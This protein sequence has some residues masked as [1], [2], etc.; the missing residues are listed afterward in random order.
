MKKIILLL[1]LL[2]L[3]GCQNKADDTLTVAVSIVPQETFV[4]KVAG[5]LIDVVV[6][7]PPGNSPA[8]YQP[9]PQMMAKFN[10]SDIYFH[11]DVSAEGPILA[12]IGN[13]MKLVDLAEAVDEKYPARYFEA[14]E[15]DHEDEHSHEGRDPH[16]WLSPKRTMVMVEVIR[17][18][19]ITLDPAHK[20]IYESNAQSYL[21][22]LKVLDSELKEAFDQLDS[23]A[24][25]M[26][27]PSFG[28]F[29]EDYNLDMYAIEVEGK[30]AT[31]KELGHIIE[32]AKDKNIKYVFYQEEFDSQ[33]A[34]IVANEIGGE[35]IKVAP[36]SGDYI[37]NL[38]M[39][40][41][42]MQD[43]LD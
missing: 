39:I 12:S 17:D 24:F 10:E 41:N 19:L 29:A 8:N 43:I 40:L 28:Y 38:R 42:K 34:E 25:I 5:D 6:M 36:L 35:T 18:E 33:Q 4:K 32:L 23:K 20:D 9:T 30:D 1:L 11:I 7:I 3:V 13:D 16:I 27:H 14:H 21:E 2:L 22:E 37:N 26:Y 15:E 31:I